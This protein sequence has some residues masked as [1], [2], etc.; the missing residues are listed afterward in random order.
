MEFG[1]KAAKSP[2]KSGRIGLFSIQYLLLKCDLCWAMIERIKNVCMFLY[3][4]KMSTIFKK[5][6][7]K[8]EIWEIQRFY[9]LLRATKCEKRQIKYGLYLVMHL[10]IV[11]HTTRQCALNATV[12][13]Q[14]DRF[15][16]NE[17]VAL[18]AQQLYLKF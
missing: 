9:A 6:K 5:M 3:M 2:E 10:V 14:R 15:W 13:T 18:S 4:Y 12:C 7:W 16:A 1:S 17:S 8:I 11:D